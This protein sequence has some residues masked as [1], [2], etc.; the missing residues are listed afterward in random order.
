MATEARFHVNLPSE[1][2]QE[3]EEAAATLG[4]SVD[5]FASAVL[6]SHARSVLQRDD[7]TVLTRRDWDRFLKA[8]ED[9]KARPNPAL[10]EAAR[11]Y[12]SL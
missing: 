1:L 5:D 8:I 4:Q 6:A 12:K 9:G 7:V 10:I 11:R 2:K 3:I